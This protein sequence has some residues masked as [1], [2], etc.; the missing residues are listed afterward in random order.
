MGIF[1]YGMIFV[2]SYLFIIYSAVIDAEHL[3][4]GE[5]IEDHTS[6]WILRFIFFLL[7]ALFS[8]RA[9]AGFAFL[10]AALFDQFLN[11][12]RGKP[13][14][15]LGTVAK[16]DIFFSKRKYLYVCVK[17]IALLTSLYLFFHYV[18]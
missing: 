1:I 13:F 15:Y 5:Y 2:V 8:F 9:A 4:K 16:W 12:M 6:R 3:N 17:I 7:I 18:C 11:Y 14:W 10:F